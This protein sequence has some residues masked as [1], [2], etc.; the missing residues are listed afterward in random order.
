MLVILVLGFFLYN[1]FFSSDDIVLEQN[2]AQAAAA[3]EL[4]KMSK[5]LESVNFKQ[6]LFVSPGYRLLT[7]F[8]TPIPPE[9]SGRSNPFDLIGRE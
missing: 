3:A 5:D 4:I 2:P 9:P 8:S 7:D 6:D 1:S